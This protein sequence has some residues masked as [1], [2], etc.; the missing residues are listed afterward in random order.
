MVI[1][2]GSMPTNCATVARATSVACCAWISCVR[3]A[4]SSAWAREA[5]A[6]GRNSRIHQRVDRPQ[7]RF[8]RS[9]PACAARTVSCGGRQ[10][11]ICVRGGRAY[12]ILRPLRASPPFGTARP[13]PWPHSPAARPKSNGSQ[14][15]SA[16]HGAA[17]R[18]PEIV[19]ARSPG[20]TWTES[21][22]AE[23]ACP[24]TL[25]RVRAVHLRQRVHPRQIGGAR[26]SNAGRGSIDLLLRK[27]APT[28]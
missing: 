24:N 25:F 15:T 19:R 5:S 2:A 27:R 10:S 6:P 28:G 21:R 26:Q 4:A 16:S 1:C 14:V 18:R 20:R 9:T 7:D 17:P 12:V 13:P 11:E 23:A 3:A 8:A 22:S